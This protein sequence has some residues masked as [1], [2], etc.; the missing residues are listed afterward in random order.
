MK[1]NNH[2]NSTSS[3]KYRIYQSPAFPIV[4]LRRLRKSPAIRDLLQETHLSVTDLI[5][6]I[7]VQEGITTPQSIMSMPDIQ[8]IPLASLVDIVDKIVKSGI[9]ALILFGIPRLKDKNARSA[10]NDDGIVQQS[11]EIIR[12]HFS[13][14]IV[15]ITDVCL[16]QYTTE[17]HCGILLR[18]KIDNDESIKIL[19]KV[20]VSHAHAGA[21][22]VAPSAMMDGQV[23]AIR[24]SL[25]ET[26]F[27][28]VAIMGYSAK[29]AS[30]MYAPFRD[31][32]HSSPL[33]GDRKA[34]Q[35]PFTNPR[36]ALREIQADINEGVDIVMIKPALP[37]LDLIYQARKYTNLPICAYSV[38]GEYALIKAASDE[39]WIDEAAVVTELLTSVKRAGADMIITYHALKMAEILNR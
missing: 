27:K 3:K 16:C 21:D 20:A 4:R 35:M 24:T 34:Y 11:V 23:A 12:K 33:F 17:G 14:K 1:I 26:G 2:N 38:S 13:D 31:A 22:I 28:D 39:G 7:F 30:P 32:A 37:Y 25:D 15:I 8:R 5:S 36:E 19:A 18:K 10:Y 9:K 29:H 6:P